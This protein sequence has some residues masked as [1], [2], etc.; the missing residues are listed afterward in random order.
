MFQKDLAKMKMKFRSKAQFFI[1]HSILNIFRL[2]EFNALETNNIEGSVIFHHCVDFQCIGV[3]CRDV[4]EER[5]ENEILLLRFY[6]S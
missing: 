5:S 6:S 2:R 1:S 4:I 3:K